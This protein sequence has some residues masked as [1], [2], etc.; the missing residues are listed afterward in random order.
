MK[1]PSGNPAWYSLLNAHDAGHGAWPTL[2]KVHVQYLLF[3]AQVFVS[4]PTAAAM[5]HIS[6]ILYMLYAGSSCSYTIKTVLAD[7]G[8]TQNTSHTIMCLDI[9]ALF[10]FYKM[11]HDCWMTIA[12]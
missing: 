3:L 6:R 12:T 11:W 2:S 1:Y 7:Q 8:R 4:E 9:K 5:Q 10:K